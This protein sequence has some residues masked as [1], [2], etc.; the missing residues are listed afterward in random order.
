MLTSLTKSMPVRRWTLRTLT[1]MSALLA[2]GINLPGYAEEGAKDCP[3]TGMVLIAAAEG[4]DPPA[5]SGT[6]EER[7]VP[8]MS[9]GRPPVPTLKGAV[10]EGNRLRVLPGYG[11]DV[12]PDGSSFMMRPAGGGTGATGRCNCFLPGSGPGGTC[13]AKRDG[14]DGVKC[15]ANGCDKCSIIIDNAAFGGGLKA[16]Q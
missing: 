2:L 5:D 7:A 13:S 4:T 11:L 14:R 16:I 8:R 9:P 15:V 6:V 3:L 1:L 10:M 12:Q